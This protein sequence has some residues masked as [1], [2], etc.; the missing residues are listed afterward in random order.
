MITI[1]K[2]ITAVSIGDKPDV[3]DNETT[4]LTLTDKVVRPNLL[5]GTTYKIKPPTQDKAIYITI[6]D[7]KLDDRTIV[8]YEIFLNSRDTNNAQWVSALTVIMSA[9]FRK[10]GD[11]GFLIEELKD[12]HD[13]KGG[14]WHKQR[15]IPSVVTEI[16]M[17]LEDHIAALK[18]RDKTLDDGKQEEIKQNDGYPSS[19]SF[20][21]ECNVKALVKTDGCNKCLACGYSKCG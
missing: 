4:T 14:Y 5:K 15:F 16:A 10:G 19:A 18:P 17:V 12:I 13:P 1:D 9:L 8:P 7:Y 20:C 21:S 11:I 6:N 2:K 3:I